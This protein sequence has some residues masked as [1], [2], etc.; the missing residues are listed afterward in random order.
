MVY[1]EATTVLPLIGSYVFHKGDWKNREAKN[2]AKI[3]L[4]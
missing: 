2:W 4:K 1:A 3:F